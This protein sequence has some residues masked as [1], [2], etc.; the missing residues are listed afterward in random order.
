MNLQDKYSGKLK[1]ILKDQ[2]K[3]LFEKS[4]DAIYLHDFMGNFIGANPAALDLLG[5]SSEEISTI[6][7]SS[8]LNKNQIKIAFEKLK[9]IIDAG[10][11]QE[12]TEYMLKRKNGRYIWVEAQATLIYKEGENGIIL[13]LARDI[14]KRKEMEYALHKSEAKYRHMVENANDIIIS[15]DLNGRYKF[16]NQAGLNKLGYSLEE[17]QELS[18]WND[19][20]PEEYVEETAHFYI[21]QFLED[22]TET[23]HE[24]PMKRKDGTLLWLGHS[25]KVIK[26]GKNSG[27]FDV[28]R[29][30]TDLRKSR[31]ELEASEKKFRN[32][33]ESLKEGFYEVDI[34]GNYVYVND[35]MCSMTGFTKEE[36]LGKSY[37]ECIDKKSKNP[38]KDLK[39]VSKNTGSAT[40]RK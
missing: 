40:R 20:V 5:Y 28:A 27:F 18:Y 23:Y 6:D 30:I 26:E 36:V 25:V 10:A 37:K 7:F 31:M 19:L 17:L 24:Y 33:L 13:G 39:K 35:S 12:T 15:A 14:S 11:L 22:I 34:K 4:I 21:K 29:D 1:D 32:I 3:V 16:M 2:Y 8:L 9:E 38:P